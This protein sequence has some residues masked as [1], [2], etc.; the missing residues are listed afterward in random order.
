LLL[1][2][3]ESEELQEL[4]QSTTPKDVEKE[5][6]SSTSSSI[7]EVDVT[8]DRNDE[9]TYCQ[10]SKSSSLSISRFSITLMKAKGWIKRGKWSV[11]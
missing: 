3:D 4:I 9:T 8:N 7:I 6:T 5:S 2:I 1:P 11:K 10:S